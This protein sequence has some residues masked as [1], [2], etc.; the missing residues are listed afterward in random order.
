[1]VRG[2]ARA[3]RKLMRKDLLFVLNGCDWSFAVFVLNFMKKSVIHRLA[4]FR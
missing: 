2:V 1:M 4:E 3:L